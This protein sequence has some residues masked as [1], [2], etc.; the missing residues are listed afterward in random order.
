MRNTIFVQLERALDEFYE[1]EKRNL[2]LNVHEIAHAHR[3]AVYFEN[4]LRRYDESHEEKLFKNYFVD[5]EFNRT[6]GGNPKEVYYNNELHKKRSDILLHSKGLVPEQENLLIIE[7]K[8]EDSTD[9]EK[10]DICAIK[11]MVSPKED[12][13][14]DSSICNTH[15]GVYLKI[16][17]K[18][19]FG[20]KFWYEDERIV[21]KCF[22]K[23]INSYG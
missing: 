3:L 5:V 4:H 21:S 18:C 6:E 10:E 12:G 19:Y 23:Q 13:T 22:H 16:G 7:L 17:E 15:L 20:I 14:P 2:E 1:K 8:K 11:R 9:K